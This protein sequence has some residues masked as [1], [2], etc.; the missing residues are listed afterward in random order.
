MDVVNQQALY[1]M[2]KIVKNQAII[3]KGADALKFDAA[4]TFSFKLFCKQRRSMSLL[5]D[6]ENQKR[7]SNCRRK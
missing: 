1:K 6:A 7:T 5:I 4:K 2:T 3:K